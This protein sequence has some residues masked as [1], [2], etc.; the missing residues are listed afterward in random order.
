MEFLNQV[1]RVIVGA[2]DSAIVYNRKKALHK[3]LKKM[4]QKENRQI[5]RK[6]LVL[7]KYYYE[8]LQSSVSDESVEK[9]CRSIQFSQERM[10]K[11]RKRLVELQSRGCE[12][13]SDLLPTKKESLAET[14]EKEKAM[15]KYKMDSQSSSGSTEILEN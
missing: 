13:D 6:Y 10:T 15:E 11:V 8:N 12:Q 4:I 7:G 1:G 3:R 2:M 9:V 14:P 5:N